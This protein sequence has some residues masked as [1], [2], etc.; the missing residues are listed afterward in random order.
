MR[1]RKK[2]TRSHTHTHTH[3]HTHAMGGNMCLQAEQMEKANPQ[4]LKQIQFAEKSGIPWVVILGTDE[5]ERG[6]V[7]VSWC[8]G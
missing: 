3:T 4:L 2:H 6:V 1:G 5:I 8:C 7:K